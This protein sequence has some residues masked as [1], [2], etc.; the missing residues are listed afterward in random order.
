MI[1]EKRAEAKSEL[2]E[3]TIDL[4]FGWWVELRPIYENW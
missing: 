1:D 2:N 4:V 3:H